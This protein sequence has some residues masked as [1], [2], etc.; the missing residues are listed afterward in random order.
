MVEEARQQ[1]GVSLGD[2][3]TERH[4]LAAFLHHTGL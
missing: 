3:P 2:T 1:E 4:A